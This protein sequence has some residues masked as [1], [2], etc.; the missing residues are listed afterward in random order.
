MHVFYNF[1]LNKKTGF[2]G[3]FKNNIRRGGDNILIENL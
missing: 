2:M 3:P 1:I